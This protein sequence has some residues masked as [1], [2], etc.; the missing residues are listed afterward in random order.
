MNIRI[1][2][3]VD[4]LGTG[5]TEEGIRK[6]LAGLDKTIFEQTVCTISGAA[7]VDDCSSV[8]VY[9]LGE[10]RTQRQLIV[11][12][13]RRVFRDVRPHVV[14]SRNWGS[15]E[16]IPAARLARI[17][18]VVHSEHGF[19]LDFLEHQSWRR[20]LGRK[21]FF[22]FADRVLTVSGA[23]RDY[24]AGQ[25]RIRRNCFAVIPNGVDTQRYCPRS[26]LRR[27]TREK[28]GVPFD[29]TLVGTVGRLD[30]IKDH[31]TLFRALESLIAERLRVRLLV[32]GDGTYRN[33]LEEHLRHRPFLAAATIFVGSTKD[34]LSYLNALDIFVLPSVIEGMS[35]ALLEAMAVGLPC[36][37]TRV[38]GN[39][40]LI[41][42][43]VSGLLFQVGNSDE[44][45]VHLRTLLLNIPLQQRLGS[46][47]RHRAEG[48]FRLARMIASYAQLYEDL[49][50]NVSR[51]SFTNKEPIVPNILK[52][53]G[54]T[55]QGRY[56]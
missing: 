34:V 12:M 16:A 15:I 5:G 31:R 56:N 17:P 47:A 22:A 55:M 40:E 43:Q 27:T 29:T 37:A 42:D 38:G 10:T 51:A 14:H 2:H 25:L 11:G 3:V 33:V 41:E 13:L 26:D 4:S 50:R 19:E 53:D 35:N 1:M 23:L 9:S 44:L 36:I 28:L 24:Y 8:P 32:V 30:A 45:A 49:A 6:I 20:Q 21:I 52:I 48:K 7:S 39:P 18:A 54:K 46:N